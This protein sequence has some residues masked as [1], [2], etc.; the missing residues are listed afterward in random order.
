MGKDSL[1]GLQ[2]YEGDPTFWKNLIPQGDRVGEHEVLA[3]TYMKGMR[4]Y[5]CGKI[6]LDC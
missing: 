3:G 1:F 4:C 6:I 5:K 2:W